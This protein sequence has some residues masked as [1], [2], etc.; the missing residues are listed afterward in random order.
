MMP[1]KITRSKG[2]VFEELGF[3]ATEAENLR[4]RAALMLELR[5]V[6][7]ERGLTQ[8]Q[9]ADVFEVTQPRVSD[10]VRG[11][12]ERFSIDMLVNMLA[13]ADLHV[14]VHVEPASA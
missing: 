7:E 13:Q 8:R 5:R 12:I 11:K 1:S 9:A 6:I 14:D 10:L 4:I 2:N 3:R